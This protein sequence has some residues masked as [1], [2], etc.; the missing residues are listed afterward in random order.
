MPTYHTASEEETIALG[1]RLAGELP[2]R[3]VVLLTGNL[4]AGKTTLASLLL[5]FYD[6]TRGAIRIGGVDIREFDPRELRRHF[7]VV[8]QPPGWIYG[9]KNALYG[10]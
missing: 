7:G 10:I 6:V 8:L 3:G 2:R 1:E 9:K 4:G 5:R